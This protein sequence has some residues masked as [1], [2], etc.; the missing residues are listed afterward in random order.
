MLENIPESFLIEG[1]LND[2]QRKVLI[3]QIS[4][5]NKIKACGFKDNSP[6]LNEKGEV[7]LKEGMLI[8]GISNFD[9]N[10]V[11]NIKNTGIL[12]GQA[13]GIEE[14][15]ETYYCADFHRVDKDITFNDYSMNFSYR[16]GRCPMGKFNIGGKS[17]AFIIDKSDYYDNELFK[18]DCYREGTLESDVTKSFIN[19]MPMKNEVASSI[20]YGVPSNFI[21][22]IVIGNKL[23]KDREVV[24]FLVDTFPNC[25]LIGK[26]G[27]MI[28]NPSEKGYAYV[29]LRREML[30]LNN[31]KRELETILMYK[32]KELCEERDKNKMFSDSVIKN[33]DADT[34]YN[35]FSDAGNVQMAEKYMNVSDKE[36]GHY[37]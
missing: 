11:L 26:F 27:D 19:Y 12:T 6:I 21:V 7:I 8:H 25:Y 33:C 16:D 5:F 20:L 32:E 4:R 28:Y 36:Q 29:E 31:D 1:E 23:V 34:L 24:K 18:Y 22:G 10:K 15:G 2:E 3:E 35:I 13:L 30:C 14:D 37:R 9:F 17:L